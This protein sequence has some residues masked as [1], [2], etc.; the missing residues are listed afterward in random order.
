MSDEC[1]RSEYGTKNEMGVARYNTNE[2]FFRERLANLSSI[3]CWFVLRQL[4][5]RQQQNRTQN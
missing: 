4:Q 2:P 1:P 3:F 5:R